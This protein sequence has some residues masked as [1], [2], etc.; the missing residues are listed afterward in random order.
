MVEIRD[1]TNEEYHKDTE[2]VSASK[3]KKAFKTMRHY[4]AP[5]KNERKPHFDIGHAFEIKLTDP[6]SYFDE[7]V[8][9]DE[10]QRPDLSKTMAAY[11][12]YTW[13]QQ[14]YE[15]HSD[16]YIITTE[17]HEMIDKMVKTC[18]ADKVIN[19]LVKRGDFQMSIFWDH[20]GLK[21]KT[22][23]DILIPVI[24]KKAIIID[25]KSTADASPGGFSRQ[26]KK[27]YYPF[28]AIMQVIGAE[29][30]GYEVVNYYWLAVE[31]SNDMPLA[32]LYEFDKGDQDVMRI[33]FDR[34]V[35]KVLHY[36]KTQE[37][38]GYEEG[39]ENDFGIKSLELGQNYLTKM[40][41]V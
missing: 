22:R 21:V 26:A 4:A 15:N 3:L 35:D 40:R 31:K 6:K 36:N 16:K 29:A 20:K 32:Q 8:V 12:N 11:D 23:P 34:I 39:C 33:A 28:Q 24:D 17:D 13:K 7:V 41:N 19:N 2:F 25:I 30:L 37:A 5:S 1:I 9:F 18:E 27:L 10:N 14:F 38:T